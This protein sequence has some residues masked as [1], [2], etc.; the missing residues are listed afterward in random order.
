MSE[1]L[2][3]I[4]D[5][6]GMSLDVTLSLY[7]SSPQANMAFELPE[8]KDTVIFGRSPDLPVLIPKEFAAVQSQN[9]SSV[10][11]YTCGPNSMVHTVANCTAAV[12]WD[13]V[14]GRSGSLREV[15]LVR[16]R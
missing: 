8:L 9:I 14:K 15:K 6:Q 12:Q 7:S 13:I 11:V 1:Y 16:W 2:R 5:A 10:G 4:L 3:D